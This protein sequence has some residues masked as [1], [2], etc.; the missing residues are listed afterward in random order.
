MQSYT[1]EDR[2]MTLTDLLR[3]LPASRDLIDSAAHALR[4]APQRSIASH[5]GTLGLGLAIGA[6]IALLCAPKSGRELRRH[7][8]ARLD[9][10]AERLKEAEV[11]LGQP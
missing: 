4:P 2:I 3:S 11:S 6:G 9:G 5:L 10:A 8:S 1:L 7:L